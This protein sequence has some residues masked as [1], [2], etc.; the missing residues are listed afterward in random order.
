MESNHLPNLVIVIRFRYATGP[1]LKYL[2]YNYYNYL[3]MSEYGESDP[4]CDIIFLAWKASAI[5]R[6][7][8]LAC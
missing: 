6:Y 2:S 5:D 1:N 4:R 8:T 7:A 3:I